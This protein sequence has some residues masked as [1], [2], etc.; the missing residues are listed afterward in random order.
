MVDENQSRGTSGLKIEEPT[1]R[2]GFVNHPHL[3]LD[4][5]NKG[6][7]T[8]WYESLYS[9][10]SSRFADIPRYGMGAFT[11]LNRSARA[12][13]WFAIGVVGL[14]AAALGYYFARNRGLIG[15]SGSVTSYSYEEELA[16]YD[17]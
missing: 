4:Q 9:N 16:G 5:S 10:L 1:E 11:S 17:E 14:G 13:P 2:E 3:A 15:S 12:N 6:S 7:G 8:S